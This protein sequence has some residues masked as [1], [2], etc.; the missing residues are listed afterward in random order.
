MISITDSLANPSTMEEKEEEEE[1]F[2]NKTL[3]S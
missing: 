2:W 3:E 1:K